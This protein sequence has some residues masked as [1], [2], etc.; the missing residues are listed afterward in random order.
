MFGSLIHFGA[1][2]CFLGVLKTAERCVFPYIC[3]RGVVPEE[4]E[5]LENQ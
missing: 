3:I 4:K 1:I 2:M 5:D